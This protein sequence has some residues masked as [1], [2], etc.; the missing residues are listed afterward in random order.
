ME[1]DEMNFEDFWAA[2]PRKSGKGAARN[3]FKRARTKAAVEDIFAGLA[4][5]LQA[6]PW[7]G[8]IQFC[9]HPATWLN[10]ERWDDEYEAPGSA[11]DNAILNAAR[12]ADSEEENGE[13]QRTSSHLRLI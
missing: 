6:E 10:Q 12:L 4:K 11:I 1:K 7:R 2:Y 3:S 5:F 13:H 9:P 8:D